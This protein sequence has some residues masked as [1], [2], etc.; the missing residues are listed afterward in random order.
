MWVEDLQVPAMVIYPLYGRV[1]QQKGVGEGKFRRKKM[2]D[3][4]T[5]QN[6][7]LSRNS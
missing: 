2:L 7:T 5:V 1:S 3:L 6:E 4:K